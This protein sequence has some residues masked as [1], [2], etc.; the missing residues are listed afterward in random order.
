MLATVLLLQTKGTAR[1]KLLGKFFICLILFTS[2]ATLFMPAEVG[3][4]FFGHFGF[5]HLLSLNVIIGAVVAWRAA[6]RGDIKTHKANMIG[7]YV[8]GFLVAGAFA[9]MPGRLLHQWLFG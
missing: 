2:I 3:P 1:H 7:M 5:I 4:R 6:R 8:F 9:F